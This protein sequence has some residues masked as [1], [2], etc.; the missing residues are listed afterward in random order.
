MAEA[1]AS[2]ISA[3]MLMYKE[4]I[5][6]QMLLLEALPEAEMASRPEIKAMVRAVRGN[7]IHTFIF[8]ELLLAEKP[9][10]IYKQTPE[11]IQDLVDYIREIHCP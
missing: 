9:Y 10:L 11:T 2:G 6:N 1:A 5:L 4:A 3:N 8:V 7:R